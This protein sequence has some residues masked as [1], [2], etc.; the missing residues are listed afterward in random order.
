MKKN[1]IVLPVLM[2]FLISTAY[3]Q[4]P[5][6]TEVWEPEP[7]V[8]KPENISIE[9]PDDAITLFDGTSFGEWESLN[10]GEVEWTLSGDHMTVNPGTGG[11]KTKRNFKDIQLHIEWRAPTEIDGEGQGRGNSGIFLQNRYE[12]QV[13]DNWHNRTYSNGMAGSIY[14]QHIPLANPAKRPGEWQTYDI[15]FKAPIFDDNGNVE[16][17]ARVTVILNGV[18]VQNNVEIFGPTRYIGEPEYEAHGPDGIQLQDHTD[19]VS[20]RNIWIRELDQEII[21]SDGIYGNH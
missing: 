21:H 18:L 13:L 3:C 15:F 11:I 20:Y 8:V 4:I 16:E 19:L 17:P 12:V 1:L 10:G 7:K 9:K 5:G 14:K 6:D 2:L